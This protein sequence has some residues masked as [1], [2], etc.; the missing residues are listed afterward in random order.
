LNQEPT[1]LTSVPK[2]CSGHVLCVYVCCCLLL[3]I[4]AI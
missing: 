2:L 3:L 1:W 4:I